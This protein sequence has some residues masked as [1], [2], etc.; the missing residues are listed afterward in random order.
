M[1][2]Y[3]LYVFLPMI[4]FI[5]IITSY[6]DIK[7]GKIRNKWILAGLIYAVI[8]NMVIMI[9]HSIIGDVRIVYF[10]ELFFMGG[11]SLLVGFVLWNVGLW[12]AGDA[13]LYLTYS[14]LVPLSTYVYGHIPYLSST[15]ILMNTFVPLFAYFTVILAI[16]TSLK[17]KLHYL[18]KAFNLR[19][20]GILALFLFGFIW[21]IKI[22][23]IVAGIQ[24]D[25]FMTVFLF[26]ILM[27]SIE[28]ILPVKTI[29]IG[30]ALSILR[31]IFDRTALTTDSLLYLLI[32]LII[33]VFVRF[34]I[35][36]LSYAVLTKEVDINLLKPGMV[37]A[38]RVYVNS[39]GKYI[40]EQILEFTMFGY[41]NKS[42]KKYLFKADAKGLNSVELNKFKKLEKKLGFEHLRVHQTVSF[43]PYL[44][45]GVLLS[46]IFE[47]NMILNIF[48]TIFIY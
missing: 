20:M 44:F 23:F 32:T 7:N 2:D 39:K 26:F 21:V 5:G 45:F 22:L 37:P 41:M 12:T 19:Q 48:S 4:I 9:Y 18:K 40:K 29:Y 42:K 1:A 15:N 47:G 24:M 33:F 13:K 6:E 43:A 14:L 28:K 8:A 34:F 25:F 36:Y 11:F 16:K 46:L 38:E 30:V 27:I 31:L 17:E 3:T 10:L 35:L